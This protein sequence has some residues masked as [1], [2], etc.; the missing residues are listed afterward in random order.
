M[1]MDKPK[2]VDQRRPENQAI[3]ERIDVILSEMRQEVER[4]HEAADR[5]RDALKNLVK[6]MLALQIFLALFITWQSYEGRT[7]LVDSQRSGCERGKVDRTMISA[8]F[9]AQSDY[10]NLVLDAESVKKDVKDAAL[11][12]QSQQNK[13]ATDLKSRTGLNLDC[14]KAFPDASLLP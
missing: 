14:T 8:A 9:E 13:S 12:N 6:Y 5:K 4:T 7:K 1:D 11:V 3:R 2:K 10:L